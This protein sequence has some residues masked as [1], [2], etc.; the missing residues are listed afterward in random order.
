[1]LFVLFRGKKMKINFCL[2]IFNNIFDINFNKMEKALALNFNSEQLKNIIN[3]CYIWYIFIYLFILLF[4]A[5]LK[6]VYME[7]PR[8]GVKSELHLPDYATAT[9][10]PDP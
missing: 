5:T 6:S 4:R 10:T 3:T 2:V 7:V 1:M 8:L 9:A